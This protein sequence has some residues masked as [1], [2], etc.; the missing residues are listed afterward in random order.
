MER[1]ELLASGLA[2]RNKVYMSLLSLRYAASVGAKHYHTSAKQS[3]GIQ[4]LFLDLG[5]SK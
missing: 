1:E 3:K 5:K 4:D 2:R